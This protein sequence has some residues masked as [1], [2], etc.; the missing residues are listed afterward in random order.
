MLGHRLWHLSV[1]QP[2]TTTVFMHICCYMV[3]HIDIYL[4][5]FAYWATVYD[6]G[7]VCKQH[8]IF[9]TCF[10]RC[11][12]NWTY[13][14]LTLVDI[15][16]FRWSQLLELNHRWS[17]RGSTHQKRM[18][19]LSILGTALFSSNNRVS[20]EFYPAKPKHGRIARTNKEQ[21][22]GRRTTQTR[23][24]RRFISHWLFVLGSCVTHCTPIYFTGREKPQCIP[25][26]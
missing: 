12:Y 5:L 7:P 14:V 25:L 3:I 26:M 18:R 15:A 20:G 16:C 22:A 24:R 13:V 17:L 6:G 10:L 19:L 11:L 4:M 9:V 23:R 8:K 1:I 21:F 2:M